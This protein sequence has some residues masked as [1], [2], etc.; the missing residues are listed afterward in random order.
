MLTVLTWSEHKT[1][2]RVFPAATDTQ[3]GT[4]RNPSRETLNDNVRE[5]AVETQAMFDRA[6]VISTM[7][8]PAPS[9]MDRGC[10]PG[11]SNRYRG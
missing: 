11:K 2:R 9:S 1:M 10:Q 7:P 3:Y 4:P 6:D 8:E 5:L